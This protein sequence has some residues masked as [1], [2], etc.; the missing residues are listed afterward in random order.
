L[1]VPLSGPEPALDNVAAIA[2]LKKEA[3]I[4]IESDACVSIAKDIMIA[5]LFYLEV[6]D[7]C[8]T[9]N[10]MHHCS[11]TIYCRL[12]LNFI[13]QKRFYQTLQKKHAFF[14]INSHA[15][16]CVQSLPSRFPMFCRTI[17]L[18]LKDMTD[19][20]QI[21]ISGV[22][23]KP[24]LISGMPTQLRRLVTAQD[25]SMPFG[26]IDNQHV[27]KKLPGTPRKRSAVE[28]L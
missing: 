9:E 24:T 1:N 13:E 6:D 19:K 28:M 25:L 5:L 26:C 10:S 16:P 4:S 3:S 18:F 12:L 2:R 21:F 17:D 11:A 27:E 14:V 22:T 23:S 20:I 8:K 7:L 15:L